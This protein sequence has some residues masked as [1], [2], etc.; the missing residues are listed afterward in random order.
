MWKP[1]QQLR[2]AQERNALQRNLPAFEFH[3]LVRDTYV[4]GWWTSNT[5]RHYQ[6]RVELPEGYPDETPR[7]YVTYPTPLYGYRD[8]YRIDSYG[9]NH[10]MHTW[11][12]DRPGWVKV[13]IVRPKVWSAEYSLIKVLRKAMLW[14]TAYECHLDDGQA[15][16]KFLLD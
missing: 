8:L 6:I 10:D 7:T 16:A 9:N 14:I 4:T 13:C 11:E 5:N 1:Y 12:T 3:N 2:L 15:I